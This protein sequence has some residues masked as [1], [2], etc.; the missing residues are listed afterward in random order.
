MKRA[1]DLGG[2]MRLMPRN[3]NGLQI[4]I[5]PF[6][7]VTGRVYLLR[8]LMVKLASRADAACARR[9]AF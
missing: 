6:F 5:T 9:Y 2:S 4:P 1:A 8:L 7:D 3:C